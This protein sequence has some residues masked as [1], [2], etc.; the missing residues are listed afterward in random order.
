K[1]NRLSNIEDA[2]KHHTSQLLLPLAPSDQELDF[3]IAQLHREYESIM[4]PDIFVGQDKEGLGRIFQEAIHVQ[5][6]LSL[7]TAW[8]YCNYPVVE[9]GSP[10]YGMTFDDSTMSRHQ[11]STIFADGVALI[12][13]PALIKRGDS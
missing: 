7:Q 9:S 4:G 12:I 8:W 10:P 2:W 3:A 13:P 6:N 1:A 5:T 11:S